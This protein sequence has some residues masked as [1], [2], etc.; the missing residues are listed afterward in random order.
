[1]FTTYGI[2]VP[3][4]DYLLVDFL[5]RKRATVLVSMLAGQPSF[6][7]EEIL[8]E[9]LGLV[10]EMRCAVHFQTCCFS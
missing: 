4:S 6:N 9:T 2:N 10:T 7:F 1:M 8:E 5:H 3:A